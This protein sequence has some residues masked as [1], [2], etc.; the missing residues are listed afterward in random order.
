MWLKLRNL[1]NVVE[2]AV[3]IAFAETSKSFI[4]LRQFKTMLLVMNIDISTLHK[5]SRVLVKSNRRP[6]PHLPQH[7]NLPSEYYILA[8]CLIYSFHCATFLAV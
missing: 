4:L 2:I 6:L 8:L 5:M 7:P 1:K 3:A